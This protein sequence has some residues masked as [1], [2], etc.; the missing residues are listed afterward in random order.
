MVHLFLSCHPSNACGLELPSPC[1][2][3]TNSENSRDSLEGTDQLLP[4]VPVFTCSD[5]VTKMP[6]SL[7][8]DFRHHCK[9][10]SD[11]TFCGHPS[12]D[13]FACNNGQCVFYSKRCDSVSDCLDD[14]DVLECKE[15]VVQI[16]TPHAVRPPALINFDGRHFFV[17]TEMGT[18]E[19]CPETHYLCP[20]GYND[21]LLVY[22]RCNGWYDCMDHEDEEA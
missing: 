3:S 19:T 21:C 10:R 22:T 18:N 7:V 15:Y 5:D 6:Y 11:E 12:C 14:S 20:G 2:F 13:A 4:P 16:E 1:T 17:S 8:C 9:D